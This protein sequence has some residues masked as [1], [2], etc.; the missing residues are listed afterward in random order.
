[1][2]G[3]QQTLH[4]IIQIH[5]IPS[6]KQTPP[7]TLYGWTVLLAVCLLLAAVTVLTM[8][9]QYVQHPIQYP[10]PPPPLI[11]LQGWTILLPIGHL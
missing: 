1:M 5:P 11:L 2:K 7:M 3:Q 8:I 6:P 4:M 10:E 9:L